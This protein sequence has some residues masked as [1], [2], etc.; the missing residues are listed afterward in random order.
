MFADSTDS[1]WNFDFD[2]CLDGTEL[3]DGELTRLIATPISVESESGISIDGNVRDAQFS[4]LLSRTLDMLRSDGATE[5]DVAS[6]DLNLV[7]TENAQ[8]FELVNA[9][10]RYEQ[11]LPFFSPHGR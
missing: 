1:G 4:G 7:Y 6:E 5:R 2:N 11:A 8:T 10:T 3:I 9:N